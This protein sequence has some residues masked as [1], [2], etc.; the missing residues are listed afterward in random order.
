M[1]G[2][3]E[4]SWQSPSNIAIVKYWGKYGRQYPRNCSLSFTLDKAHTQTTLMYALKDIP[5]E[6]ID[7]TFYFEGRENPSFGEKSKK[8]LTEIKDELP[9]LTM[10]K[11]IIKTDNTFPH[12]SGIASSASGMSALAMCLCQMECQVLGRPFND[13]ESFRKRASYFS[14]LG[15]GSACRSVY[16]IMASWGEH[17]EIND[18][19]NDFATPV[20]HMIHDTFTGYHDDIL[21]VS[22]K[23]K[24]VSSTAGH[25]LMEG[26]PFAEARYKQ[27]NENISA[28]LK[29]LKEGDVNAFGKIAEDEA[30]TL[31]ALMMCSNPSFI[32]MEPNTLEM[33]DRIR[34]FRH[35][36]QVPVYFTLDAGPNIHLLYPDK[37]SAEVDKFIQNQ[38]V[39]LCD[40]GTIIKDRVGQGAQSI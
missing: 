10:Y 14:R 3:Q 32:L 13:E 38:L 2:Y 12:S 20:G 16:P 40:N 34:K 28:L 35:K 23:E 36:T 26:N 8:F 19:S 21:I 9:F 6:D 17:L 5:S 1:Q 29:A 4:V 11:L 7:L 33:I 25:G 18:S 30:L 15:S 24:S 22:R 31:H 37:A 27:A 39:E